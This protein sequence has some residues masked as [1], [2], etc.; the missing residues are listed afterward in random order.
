M[1]APTF[2]IQ[3]L[4]SQLLEQI[5]PFAGREIA[6]IELADMPIETQGKVLRVLVDQTFL[7]VGND[8]G[9]ARV[10]MGL[11]SDSGYPHAGRIDFVDN[12]VDPDTGTVE[13]RPEQL[14][15]WNGLHDLVEELGA[16]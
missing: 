11:A 9:N 7:R 12:R 13:G 14:E 15:Y 8:T 5:G 6:S 1:T 10:Q 4:T 16:L 3:T 2:P